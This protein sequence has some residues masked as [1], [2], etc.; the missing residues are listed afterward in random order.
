MLTLN[1]PDVYD[2]WT[3]HEIPFDDP[4][5]VKAF[6]E[7]GKIAKTDGEVYGGVAARS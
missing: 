3:S 6:D 1:G 2:Q 4:Q 5:I 7:F